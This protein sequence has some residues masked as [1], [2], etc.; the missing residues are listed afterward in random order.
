LTTWLLLIWLKTDF[1]EWE[2]TCIARGGMEENV[3]KPKMKN[4]FVLIA[5]VCRRRCHDGPG[6]H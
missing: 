2:Y 4:A 3:S 1:K 6:L 5:C